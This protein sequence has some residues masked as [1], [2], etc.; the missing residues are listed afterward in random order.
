MPVSRILES[1]MYMI[2]SACRVRLPK[3]CEEKI[4]VLFPRS[5]RSRRN[6]SAKLRVRH[7]AITEDR[8]TDRVRL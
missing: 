7:A 3:R 6:K 2:R 5:S 1:F 8:A 4:I